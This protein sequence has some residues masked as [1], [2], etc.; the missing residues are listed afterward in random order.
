MQDRKVILEKV[1]AIIRDVLDDETLTI[2]EE[3]TAD[4]V[5]DWDSLSH[6]SIVNEI[7]NA[8]KIKFSLAEVR[9]SQ[10]VGEFITALIGHLNE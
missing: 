1:E 5:E 9:N 3:T 7:E 10:N 4:D 2:T 6:L 8:F